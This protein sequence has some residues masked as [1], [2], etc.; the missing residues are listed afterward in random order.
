[1]INKLQEMKI[2]IFGLGCIGS[3]T[4]ELLAKNGVGMLKLM[5][6]GTAGLSAEGCYKTSE[7]QGKPMLRAELEKQRLYR[8]YPKVEAETGLLHSAEE[9]FEVGRY[10]FVLDALDSPEEKEILIKNALRNRVPLISCLDVKRRS[11]PTQVR[12]ASADKVQ[13]RLAQAGIKVFYD[14]RSKAEWKVIYSEEEPAREKEAIRC[15]NCACPPDVAFACER[16][17]ISRN[18]CN[19]YVSAMAGML[20]GEEILIYLTHQYPQRTKGC[21]S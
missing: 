5:D 7:I 20:A 19:V 10:D 13:D 2:A 18:S 15:L 3:Y 14:I 12:L 21:S 16:R 6:A 17:R 9:D 11:N 1:M 8:L 4:A